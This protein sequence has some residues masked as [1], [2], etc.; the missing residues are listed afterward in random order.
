MNRA[1]KTLLKIFVD[2]LE[3]GKEYSEHLTQCD[4]DMCRAYKAQFTKVKP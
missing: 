2:S 3:D 1:T 4:C